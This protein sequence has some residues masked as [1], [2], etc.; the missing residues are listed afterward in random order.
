M[1]EENDMKTKHFTKAGV[2]ALA[3]LLTLGHSPLSIAAKDASK[4]A[5][6]HLKIRVISD[7]HYFSNELY[8]NCD[9]FT[10]AENSDRK[11]FKE[12]DAILNSAL[13]DV[14]NDKPDIVLVSGDLTKDGEKV[15]HQLFAQKL[16]DTQ[17]ALQAQGADTKFY[18]INGNHDVNNYHAKDFSSGHAVDAERTSVDDFKDIY[19]DLGYGQDNVQFKEKGTQGGALSYVARPKEGYTLIA[20]DSGK[21]S[22]DQTSSGKDVQETGGVIGQELLDWVCEQAETAKKRGDVVMVMQHHGVVP[23][24]DQ[25]PTFMADYLVDNYQ[26]VQQA[27]ADAGISYVFSGHMHANDVASYTSPSGNTVY[28]IETGSLLTYPSYTREAVVSNGTFDNGL[29][30]QITLAAKETKNVVY[31]DPDTQQTQTITDLKAYGKT[32]TLSNTV[33]K[34]MVSEGVLGPMMDD[35]LAKGGSKQFL[36]S[37]FGS[38]DISSS[39]ADLAADILPQDKASGF[40]ISF[41]G[42]NF[43]LYYDAL[44]KSI[45]ISQSDGASTFVNDGKLHIKTDKKQYSLPLSTT[46][47]DAFHNGITTAKSKGMFDPIELA[48][49]Q[50]KLIGFL[51]TLF[52]NI[53]QHFLTD[54]EVLFTVTDTLIDNLLNA[55]V[56][57]THTVFDF[58]NY[59]YQIH[60]EGNEKAEPWAKSVLQKIKDEKLL[61]QVIKQAITDTKPVLETA[62]ANLPLDLT[63]VLDKG[64]D[65]LLTTTAYNL[66]TDMI[67]D[68]SDVV[69][70]LDFATLLPDNSL[71]QLNTLAYDIAYSMSHDTNHADDN[72][73]TIK[74]ARTLL[75]LRNDAQKALQSAKQIPMQEYT[76]ESYQVLQ[77]AIANLENVLLSDDAAKITEAVKQLQKAQKNLIKIANTGT[78]E[79]VKPDTVVQ[80]SDVQHVPS[81]SVNTGDSWNS[82]SYVLLCILSGMAIVLGLVFHKRQ[83]RLHS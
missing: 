34:T 44:E 5:S 52:V 10:L 72:A 31:T 17:H 68:G 76:K 78:V 3:T 16:R 50:T 27:Y 79:E 83:R 69:A 77:K 51:D 25:E 57:D 73:A 12:S 15:N 30:S 18:V 80:Q 40:D 59:V 66:I 19:K 35:I 4:A 7:T 48:I 22:S 67:K 55:H 37:M 42:F 14:V 21:H 33:I 74:I 26:Q 13:Q 29:S 6:D 41:S 81:P 38:H 9:D 36:N 60:L 82:K 46:F 62:F 8:S 71:N 70:M 61:T 63:T 24:F 45:R 58:V 47:I 2:M 49:T 11:M 23:H 32:K 53:D 75:E 64:N 20:V 1:N 28:D 43:K 39:I 56:D 54:K 65:S